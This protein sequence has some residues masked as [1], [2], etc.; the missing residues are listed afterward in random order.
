MALEE[1]RRRHRVCVLWRRACVRAQ[2]AS[3]AGRLE[4]A[5]PVLVLGTKVREGTL[6]MPWARVHVGPRCT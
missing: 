2:E 4:D 3:P 6:P 1:E 5:V